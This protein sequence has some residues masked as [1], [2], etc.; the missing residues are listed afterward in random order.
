MNANFME[1]LDLLEREK[2]VSKETILD[3]LA[4]AMVSAYK[5]SPGAAEEARVTI[6]TDTGEMIVYGQ[7][8]DEDGNVVR[9]WEDTPTDFGRIAAQTAK[10]V[11][12]QRLRDAK[13]AQ[14][15]EIYQGREGDLVTGIVQQSDFR[16]VML[17]LGNAEAVMPAGEKIPYERLERGAR[18]KALI[19]EVREESK[20]APIVASRSHPDFIRRL[21]ELEVPELVEGIVEIRAIARDAGHRTKIAVAS[22]DMNVDP[23]GACV[24]ARGSRV[25]QVVNELR[26]EKVDIVP[27]R[28]DTADFIAEAL[29]PAKVRQ[30][31]LDD[32]EMEAIVVVPD[33]ELS[34]A[35]GKEGQNARLAARLSGYRIDI[36]SETEQAGGPP[37]G[38]AE[39]EE[40]PAKATDEDTVDKTVPEGVAAEATEDVAATEAA[41]SDAAADSD[42]EPAESDGEPADSEAAVDVAGTEVAELEAAEESDDDAAAADVVT[43][44]VEDESPTGDQPEADTAQED[45]PAEA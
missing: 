14:I 32:E 8:L 24:G 23:V 29:S 34:L 44:A 27:W 20:G 2:G 4:N 16:T 31:I 36:R 41:K 45:P 12:V 26:G 42:S 10:Q 30:V 11:I 6:D 43:E 3:A 5:R 1:E 22:N 7:E 38:D 37:E 28:E 19:V 17:D 18:V 39:A 35:I 40:K 9:E 15:F 21:F 33:R 25:R 13:R